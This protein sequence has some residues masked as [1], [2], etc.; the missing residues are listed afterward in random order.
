MSWSVTTPPADEPVTLD[1]AKLHLRVD[2]DADD[3][4]I[5]A[6]IQAAREHVEAVTER[7]LMAQTWTERQDG[8]PAVLALRGGV[9]SAVASVKYVDA[10]G[11][12]QTLD[13]SAYLTDLT[14]EPA[15]VRP[16]YGTEWPTTREQP[17]AVAVQ[18]SVGYADAASVPAALKAAILLLVGD[19]YA[20]RE[21]KIDAKLVENRAVSRLLF[22]YKRVLP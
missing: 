1:E 8:F 13:P 20:N 4:L 16:V 19:L 6:L 21:A 15:T 3:T 17:G 12:Q 18:Y 14:T 7:A 22:P 9:V 2:S 10:D 5:T 11:V